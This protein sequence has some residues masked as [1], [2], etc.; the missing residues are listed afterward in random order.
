MNKEKFDETSTIVSE[1]TVAAMEFVSKALNDRDPD[2]VLVRIRRRLARREA[3]LALTTV[4]TA[5][6][7]DAAM[8]VAGL[9]VMEAWWAALAAEMKVLPPS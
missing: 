3:F 9:R 7:R 4:G 6:H 5:R 1:A 2:K 8:D